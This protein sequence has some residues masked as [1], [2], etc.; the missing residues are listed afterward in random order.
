MVLLWQRLAFYLP[1]AAATTPNNNKQKQQQ[2]QQCANCFKQATPATA[3]IE[4]EEQRNQR[5][6]C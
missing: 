3:C 1:A 5:Q 2:C 4:G 6:H